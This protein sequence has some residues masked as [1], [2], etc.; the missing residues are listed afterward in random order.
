MVSKSGRE[1]DYQQEEEETQR[2]FNQKPLAE[3]VRQQLPTA[4]NVAQQPRTEQN[5]HKDTNQECQ[6]ATEKD[7]PEPFQRKRHKTLYI[8][9]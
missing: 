7:Q 6:Q 9:F 3:E 2:E 1:V 5:Q 4:E 8:R